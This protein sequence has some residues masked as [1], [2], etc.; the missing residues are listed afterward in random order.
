MKKDSISVI[1]D[2]V[3]FCMRTYGD[4]DFFTVMVFLLEGMELHIALPD[5][6]EMEDVYF[7]YSCHKQ[8]EQLSTNHFNEIPQNTL[9]K[10][11]KVH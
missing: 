1:R 7:T 2:G 8:Q 5:Y 10:K 9:T 3:F 6:C 4:R 11:H